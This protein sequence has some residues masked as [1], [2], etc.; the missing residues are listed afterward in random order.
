MVFQFAFVTVSADFSNWFRVPSEINFKVVSICICCVCVLVPSEMSFKEVLQKLPLK[1]IQKVPFS[2][3][4]ASKRAL[5][6]PSKGELVEVLTDHTWLELW[7]NP[8]SKGVEPW[9][10][11]FEL[12]IGFGVRTL[13]W[14]L[15][16]EFELQ[17][18]SRT[19]SSTLSS[20]LFAHSLN[21]SELNS[22]LLFKS[23]VFN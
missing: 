9:V 15:S 18:S 19:H 17:Y 8:G 12:R 23:S 6:R 5:R 20:E 22:E 11:K 4:P 3:L 16:S 2:N 1:S 21:N 14:T 7:F 13:G 10:Q